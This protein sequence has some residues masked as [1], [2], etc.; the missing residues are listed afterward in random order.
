MAR[1]AIFMFTMFSTF[2]VMVFFL[3][4]Y[5]TDQG[6]N[7]AQIGT[8]IG[9]GAFISM[10]A[11][12]FWGV[13]SDRKKTI[14]MVLLTL[15]VGSLLLASGM[16]AAKTVLLIGLLY[17]AFMFFNGAVASMSE[18]LCVALAA[19]R[20]MEFGKL[21]LWGE[22]G[23]G[24]A[25]VSLGL[26]VTQTGIG[27][28]GY[29]YAG[30]MLVALAAAL[31][32]RDAKSTPEPVNLAAFGRMFRQPKLLWFLVLVLMI[33]IPHRMNDSMLAIHLERIG[34]SETQLGLAW[35]IAAFCNIP[36]MLY[37]GRLIRRYSEL[38]IFIAAAVVYIARWAIVSQAAT[39]EVLIA[40][41][42]LQGITF[43]LF[44]V[45]SVQYIQN[46]V[47][48]ELRATGM[49][50]FAVTFIGFGGLIGSSVGGSLM[51]NYGPGMVYGASAIMVAVCA[52]L[53]A[54][55]YVR[56]RRRGEMPQ[57]S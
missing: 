39:P 4:L 35:S 48:V 28:I 23:V 14:K 24:F 26:L 19:E 22:F 2:S 9:W 49:A 20:R 52:V 56:S 1:I 46:L 13:V 43:P 54:A 55:T 41:Q 34:G 31:F 10:I 44:L 16:F 40:V 50:M 6:M 32:L 5:F 53:A 45:S 27:S 17:L 47:P 8:V 12:P 51:E 15:I 33:A 7:S 18:T 37:A 3:P 36:L 30:A 42:V 38:G 25:A 11:Q 21:R 29:I 57:A